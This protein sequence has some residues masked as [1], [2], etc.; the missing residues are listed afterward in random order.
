[1][2][3]PLP[4]LAALVSALLGVALVAPSAAAKPDPRAVERAMGYYLALGDSLATGY[5]P[6]TGNDL[7]GGYVGDVYE[8]AAQRAK[9]RLAN[10]ACAGETSQTF[11]DG[12]RCDYVKGSQLEQAEHFLRAH[13]QFT[14]LIT[15]DIGANDVQRCVG[16]TGT[17]DFGCI[18]EGMQAVATNLPLILETLRAGAPNAQ[19]VV[20]DYYNP[21]LAAY[22]AGEAGKA[23]ATQST[24]LQIQLNEIIAKAAAD[25]GADLA[26]VSLAFESFTTTPT[27]LPGVGTVPRNVARIC[28]WTW[29]CVR[30][31]IHAN[32]AWYA[33]MAQTVI[34]ELR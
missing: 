1:M 9:M 27:L 22:L 31:D 24:Y 2:R 33:V 13:G 3:R 20:L 18:A 15:I 34:A 7:D 16:G 28:T 6:T 30:S 29:M 23:L 8:A 19:I 25:V 21:F 10:I 17:I 11:V 14:R 32:D 12:G 4:L 5:Q 26:E